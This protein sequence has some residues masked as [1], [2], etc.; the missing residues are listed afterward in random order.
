MK[1]VAVIL[2]LEPDQMKGQA[3]GD[4]TSYGRMTFTEYDMSI[5][6][7]VARSID[8]YFSMFGYRTDKMKVPN[9]TGRANWNF[10]QTQGVMLL[11][12]FLSLIFRK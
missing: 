1:L 10:V 5:K 8:N 2:Q 9:I 3:N 4:L 7:E 12:I 11:V 6:A